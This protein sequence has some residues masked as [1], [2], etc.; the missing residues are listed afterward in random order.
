[1]KAGRGIYDSGDVSVTT[2]RSA[3]SNNRYKKARKWDSVNLTYGGSSRSE[4]YN[5]SKIID[6]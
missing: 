2:A 5:I 4:T 6:L 3:R 1:M